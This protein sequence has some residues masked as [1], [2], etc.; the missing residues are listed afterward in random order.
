MEIRSEHG[1]LVLSGD[2]DVR[3]TQAVRA[4]LYSHLA[5]Q[6]RYDD[7][8]VAVVDISGVRS[9]DATALKMLA[10]ANRI[11]HR[12]G[13]RIRVRGACPAVRRM[14]HL[15]HLIRLVELEREPVGA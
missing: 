1:V 8:A 14:L 4:A 15:T 3:S 5:E 2:L 11:A 9:A 7:S 6:S 12:T 10:A 13:A